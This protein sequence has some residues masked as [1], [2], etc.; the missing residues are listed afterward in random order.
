MK[1][2]RQ[3]GFLISKVHRT[4]GRVFSRMLRER[5]I[6]INPAQGRILFVLWE[7]GSIPIHELAERVSLGKSTLTASLDRL[8]AMGQVMR[9]PSPDDRRKIL[10]VPT[11]K[12]KEMH[13]LYEEV[14]NEMND[15]F[16]RGFSH[17]EIDQFEDYLQRV[18]N[19]LV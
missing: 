19:N 12:N 2:P 8:E 1:S 16:Y 4:A 7:S 11:P 5:N 17:K 9:V 6:D 3:G 10:I 15:V 14:S 13:A 18:L